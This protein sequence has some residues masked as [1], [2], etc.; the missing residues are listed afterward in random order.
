MILLHHNSGIYLKHNSGVYVNYVTF[1]TIT[2]NFLSILLL[3]ALWILPYGCIC[4]I[5]I[6]LFPLC[7]ICVINI[8]LFSLCETY[9][10]QFEL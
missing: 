2:S 7:E 8:M 10:F 9:I 1:S 6:I 4:V 3:T 5:N